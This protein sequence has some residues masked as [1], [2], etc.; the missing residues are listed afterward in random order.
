MG[1]NGQYQFICV[2]VFLLVLNNNANYIIG[3]NQ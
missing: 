1:I 3:W 2:S